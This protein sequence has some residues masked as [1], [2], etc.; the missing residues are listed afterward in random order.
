MADL[1]GSRLQDAAPAARGHARPQ[2]PTCLANHST[3]R[4]RQT[5]VRASNRLS[6]SSSTYGS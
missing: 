2:W 6:T 5:F 4:S 1:G 3:C